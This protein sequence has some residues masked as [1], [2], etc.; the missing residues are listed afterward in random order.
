M[1]FLTSYGLFL[2]KSVTF[3]V[4]LLI[5]VAG[6]IAIS[7]KSKKEAS[8]SIEVEALNDSFDDMEEIIKEAVLS[9]DQLK[10]E[11]KAQKKIDKEQAKARKKNPEA[12]TKK[13]VYVLNFDG[14]MKASAVE[15]LREE[16]TAL[17]TMA[18]P[19]DE[20][21]L[22]LESPG[23]LV[24]SYGLAAS[25]LMRIKN[26]SIP[27]TIAVD[28][29]AA[30]GGYMMACVGDKIL[31]APFAVIG[32]I[33][34]LAQLP[35]FHRL[36]KKNDIDFELFTAGEHKRTVTMFGENTEKGK[37]KFT[38]ELEDTHAL[39]K[40]FVADNRPQVAIDD[41]ATGE[42]WYGSRALERNLVDSLQTSDEYLLSLRNDC[43]IYEIN[44]THKKTLQ[45]K[46]GLAAEAVVDRTLMKLWSHANPNQQR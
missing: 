34:V 29:V 2:A 5:A 11:H 8:G 39:F 36:L 1:E 7:S 30:S 46:L 38:E 16:I 40:S 43:D 31:A 24:H 23:G 26:K 25:Q 3:V 17:L 15:N 14:D 6:L 22:R 42:I 20:V 32:S 27:L 18:K 35:N 45:E 13:R 10:A 41:V 33:G 4:L 9:H 19:E 21:V 28:S 37:A 44:F 12:D